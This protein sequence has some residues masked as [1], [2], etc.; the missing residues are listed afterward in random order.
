MGWIGG[1]LALLRECSPLLGKSG[2]QPA[3]EEVRGYPVTTEAEKIL[4][5]KCLGAYGISPCDESGLPAKDHYERV[6]QT[7][8][9]L[10]EKVGLMKW[11]TEVLKSIYDPALFTYDEKSCTLREAYDPKGAHGNC[12]GRVLK[13]GVLIDRLARACPEFE[14]LEVQAYVKHVRLVIT[15][16]GQ[17]YLLEGTRPFPW[18]QEQ[19]TT[20]IEF[21][22]A[23]AWM[24]SQEGA[25]S[26]METINAPRSQDTESHLAGRMPLPTK[27]FPS[28]SGSTER[29]NPPSKV[30]VG[31][32]DQ[33]L[34]VLKRARQAALVLL[35]ASP[36]YLDLPS[37]NE[38]STDAAP[39]HSSE[40]SGKDVVGFL[41]SPE[42]GAEVDSPLKLPGLADFGAAALLTAGVVGAISLRKRKEKKP[43]AAESILSV[44][45]T[46]ST[47]A[48]A[49][50]SKSGSHPSPEAQKAPVNAS[51]AE[52]TLSPILEAPS[53]PSMQSTPFE[54]D[55]R[56]AGLALLFLGAGTSALWFLKKD[57]EENMPQ[58][59]KP[60]PMQVYLVPSS[61]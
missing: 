42:E 13:I 57:Q 28:I 36:L 17:K 12:E 44:E 31:R 61:Q 24:G 39:L 56:A 41:H 15:I 22:E 27:K 43:S 49:S 9:G 37:L 50:E 11:L 52:V 2:F 30:L 21:N 29:A 3:Q 23:V 40:L 46:G 53:R 16:Q 4:W 8:K 38:S 19:G 25:G 5:G 55:L 60:Q 7:Q 45:S 18:I 54:S 48:S 20:M 1:D 33:I 26:L 6:V 14:K 58:P 32:M 47:E 10:L 34:P 51:L 59:T 35:C